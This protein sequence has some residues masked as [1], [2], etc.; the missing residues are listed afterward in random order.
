M[1]RIEAQEWIKGTRSMCNNIPQGP[2]ETWQVRI[3]QADAAMM[4]QAYYVLKTWA[5]GLIEE[6]EDTCPCPI[7]GKRVKELEDRINCKPAMEKSSG[8]RGE[9]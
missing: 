2:F 6:S 5:E 9:P 1:D 8:L 7:H 4:Q 3:A